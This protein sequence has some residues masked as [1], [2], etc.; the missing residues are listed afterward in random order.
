MTVTSDSLPFDGVLVTELTKINFHNRADG[1]HKFMRKNYFLL[2]TFN[3]ED[4]KN[5][6]YKVA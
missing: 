3:C 2:R 5:I 1:Y 4:I 6:T